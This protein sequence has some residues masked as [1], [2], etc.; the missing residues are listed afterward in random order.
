MEKQTPCS[1]C[2]HYEFIGLYG[3]G[4]IWRSRRERLAAGKL[5]DVHNT[6]QH[7]H[8]LTIPNPCCHMA[9][10]KRHYHRIKI[11]KYPHCQRPKK[12]ADHRTNTTPFFPYCFAHA[13][14]THP[15]PN[16]PTYL[17]LRVIIGPELRYSRYKMTSLRRITHTENRS[18]SA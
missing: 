12:P 15:S 8:A 5:A 11:S 3:S 17:T 4:W 2:H 9:A 6:T 13:A 14:N 10:T 16:G 7:L 18:T 1:P